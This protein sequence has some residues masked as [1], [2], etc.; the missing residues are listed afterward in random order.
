MA[1]R[2]A[3]V[4]RKGIGVNYERKV[5]SMDSLAGTQSYY[6][7][8]DSRRKRTRLIV[9]LVLIGLAL[10]AAWLAFPVAR[11]PGTPVA[12]LRRPAHPM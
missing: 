7:E 9:A 1:V 10:A 6:E 4:G 8:A 5:D 3:A 2:A 11:V 12:M